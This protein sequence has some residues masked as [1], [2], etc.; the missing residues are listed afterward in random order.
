MMS[1]WPWISL[2]RDNYWKCSP[3]TSS[4][5]CHNNP[6]L[7]PHHKPPDPAKHFHDGQTYDLKKGWI[8]GRGWMWL[9]WSMEY[10]I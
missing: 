7:D 8:Y 5:Q 1:V 6:V 3:M 2:E 10:S 9:Q 4:S